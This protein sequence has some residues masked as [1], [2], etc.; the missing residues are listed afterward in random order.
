MRRPARAVGNTA[1]AATLA[2]LTGRSPP[3]SQVSGALVELERSRRIDARRLDTPRTCVGGKMKAAGRQA[4]DGARELRRDQVMVDTTVPRA[5]PVPQWPVRRVCGALYVC[6]GAGPRSR[7]RI[8]R[9]GARD[10][11]HMLG[12][13]ELGLT[14][15]AAS[16]MFLRECARKKLCFSIFGFR[17]S[18][19]HIFLI[20]FIFEGDLYIIGKS[21]F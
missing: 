3:S 5:P 8:S 2:S 19:T 10:R 14:T 13:C 21:D 12:L 17:F 4:R 20:R 7:G 6:A 1:K 11:E 16:R 15:C 18:C 9:R